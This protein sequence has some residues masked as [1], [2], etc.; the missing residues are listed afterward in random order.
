MQVRASHCPY[1]QSQAKKLL[2]SLTSSLP[3]ETIQFPYELLQK[4]YFIP[5]RALSHKKLYNSPTSSYKKSHRTIRTLRTPYICFPQPPLPNL[6]TYLPVTSF[7]THNFLTYN[8]YL[9]RTDKVFSFFLFFLF[10][11][12]LN[13]TYLLEHQL[14]NIFLRKTFLHRFLRLRR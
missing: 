1:S 10:L 12:E 5:L 4:N 2:H 8:T 11:L 9:T 14:K 3:Q 6:H 7:T 13:V